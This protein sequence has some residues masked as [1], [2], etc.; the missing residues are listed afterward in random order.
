MNDKRV[1]RSKSKNEKIENRQTDLSSLRP[2]KPSNKYIPLRS[3]SEE[4]NT[5]DQA[6]FP[7][8]ETLSGN[9]E[10]NPFKPRSEL[11]RRSLS[12]PRKFIG[13]KDAVNRSIPGSSFEIPRTPTPVIKNLS[14]NVN[15]ETLDTFALFSN[16]LLD[17]VNSESEEALIQTTR[18][19]TNDLNTENP[20]T[21]ISNIFNI[22]NNPLEI[23]PEMAAPTVS[24]RDAVE[25]IP[26]FNGEKECQP[27]FF[28]SCD[29]ALSMVAADSENTLVKLTFSKIG[30]KVRKSLLKAPINNFAD[31]KVVL[32]RLYGPGDSYFQLC[33]EIANTY[34]KRSESVVDYSDRIRDLGD[35]LITASKGPAIDLPVAERTTLENRITKSF[36]RGL[37]QDIRLSMKTT[38]NLGAAINAALDIEKDIE[39]DDRM[40]YEEKPYRTKESKRELYFCA[41]C[42]RSDHNS[43]DCRRS[44]SVPEQCQICKK[45]GHVAANCYFRDNAIPARSRVNCQLCK[46]F[47]HEADRCPR[48]R[49]PPPRTSV[50]SLICQLCRKYGHSAETC[51]KYTNRNHGDAHNHGD[52]RYHGDSNDARNSFAPQICTYCKTP[53][54]VIEECRKK[55]YNERYQ[56]NRN[57]EMLNSGNGTGPA[58]TSAQAGPSGLNQRSVHAIASNIDE[59]LS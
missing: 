19:S 25:I 42:K 7:I 55:I 34:Q 4:A 16:N 27:E 6:A 47:D 54:H 30:S 8:S 24:L 46:E 11:R 15:S 43:E 52:T 29:L 12:L 38:E 51:F 49:P 13:E 1:T 53:G 2:A 5:L 17:N 3:G 31:L 18:K 28:D 20:I 14:A 32:L 23:V 45:R 35:R 57:A 21:P 36:I 39:V 10:D 48:Y 9:I 40:R 59:S 22:H 58:V 41:V 37:R 44:S 56:I 26:Y 50:A 33:G